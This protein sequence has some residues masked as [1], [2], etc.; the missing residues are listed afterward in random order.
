MNTCVRE[1]DIDDVDLVGPEE[2]GV[3]QH[4]TIVG[5]DSDA[6]GTHTTQRWGL[7]SL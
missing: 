1:L 7:M 2:D 4:M 6:L 3:G 5:N